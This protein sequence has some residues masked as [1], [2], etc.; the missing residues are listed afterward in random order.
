MEDV[1]SKDHEFL[2]G[3]CPQRPF[4]ILQLI[5]SFSCSSRSSCAP[6][7]RT[8]RGDARPLGITSN[9]LFLCA[10]V[11][12]CENLSPLFMR[13][14]RSF[15]ASSFSPHGSRDARPPGILTLRLARGDT[16][17][18]EIQQRLAGPASAQGYVPASCLPS[19]P[20]HAPK[21]SGPDAL[22]NKADYPQSH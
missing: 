8:A 1:R 17:P 22:R 18:P 10:S 2:E 15:A 13:S 3:C 6:T 5:P 19:N 11:P 14:M 7:L 9:P 20:I 16:G 21:A 4:I 12:L